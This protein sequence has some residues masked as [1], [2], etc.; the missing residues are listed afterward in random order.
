MQVTS[1]LLKNFTLFNDLEVF[2]LE[3]LASGS[4]LK[5]FARR[6]IV[7]TAGKN[8]NR[9]CM[10]FE[11]RLQGVD[12]TI[13]GREVGIYFVDKGDYC[14]ELCIF[15]NG[16]NPE[17]VIALN[18]SSVVFVPTNLLRDIATRHP[19]IMEKLGKKLASR[20]RQMTKQRA[21]LALPNIP[22]RV[23]NQLWMLIKDLGEQKTSNLELENSPTHM[24]MAIMLN[25]SRETVTRV[26]QQLQREKIVSRTGTNRLMINST[27]KLKLIAEGLTQL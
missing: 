5:R 23:C 21:L 13:D 25:I 2:E 20:V 18:S 3:R 17:H 16:V 15:D 14:G 22:Q 9:V 11:G 1:E 4:E 19:I 8:E 27:E 24:E 6:S 7:L 26:F 10:L 12:F